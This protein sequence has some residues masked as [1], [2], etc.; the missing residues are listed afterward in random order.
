MDVHETRGYFGTYLGVSGP[1]SSGIT[2]GP[3]SAPS[4]SAA[5]A[6]AGFGN[7]CYFTG[8]SSPTY[9]NAYDTND[10]GENRWIDVEVT[11]A[12]GGGGGSQSSDPPPPA[13]ADS[14]A[15][16]VFFP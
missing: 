16:L 1:G 13:A 4:N 7:S 11:P 2:A 12:S 5:I 3:L 8:G 14:S 10:G 15:F 6:L 9:P